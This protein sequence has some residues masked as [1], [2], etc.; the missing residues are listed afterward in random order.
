MKKSQIKNCIFL[1]LAA[2]IWGVAFVA[3]S[4]AADFIKP[5]TF[6]AV[7]CLIGGCV[8]IPVVFFFSKKDNQGS[9]NSSEHNQKLFHKDSIIGGIVCGI[10]LFAG[11][12]LQQ[13]GIELSTAGKAGFITAFY[14]VLVPVTGIFLHK[15]VR[16][17]VWFCVLLALTGLYLLCI[18]EGFSIGVGDLYLFLCALAFTA[19][20]L[21]IDHFVQKVN[22][23]ILSMEQFFVCG[24]LCSIF[25][26]L[27]E[28]PDL[29]QIYLARVPIL[30]A[31]VMSCGIAYTFQILGQR[32][33]NTTI[34]SLILSLESVVSALAGWL[35]LRE[36]LTAKELIGCG[37]M[38]VAIALTC[39][40]E[41]KNA[42][43]IRS[44][45]E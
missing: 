45:D 20:I 22:G 14:I 3:Q 21:F 5:F 25:M 18:K 24:I 29:H 32:N 35:I 28:K 16:P 36:S 43:T 6:N 1:F 13:F 2:T 4:I 39:V 44:F 31:G 10:C 40:P 33:M 9:A 41:K 11:A 12:T 23:V 27:M 30:Y 26:F 42:T 34:A 8:L 38:F 19:H 17:I 7:R 37:L 15:K